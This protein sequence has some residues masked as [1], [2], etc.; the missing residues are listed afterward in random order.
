LKDSDESLDAVI[1][2][3]LRH[4]EK[5]GVAAQAHV[6][7]MK[8]SQYARH[9]LIGRRVQSIT[10]QEVLSEL[11]KIAGLL[12]LGVMKN[13]LSTTKNAVPE[14]QVLIRELMKRLS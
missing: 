9:L 6:A 7:G 10:D 2:V 12:K 4:S 8:L 13:N 1:N 14:L 3:R 5:L 11:K